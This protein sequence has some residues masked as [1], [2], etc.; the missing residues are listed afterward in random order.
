VPVL[1]YSAPVVAAG[2]VVGIVQAGAS[3]A[4]M[5]DYLHGLRLSLVMVTCLAALLAFLGG[6]YV[7]G[8]GL[9]PIHR[10]TQTA[11][12]IGEKRDFGRRVAHVG[13]TDEVGELALTFN[14]MLEQ[15]EAAY[16]N[17]AEALQNQRRFVADASHELRTPLTTIR[18]NAELLGLDP[19][20]PRADRRAALGDIVS[21]T[22]RLIALV[23]DLLVLARA[24]A[25]QRPASE[26]VLLDGLLDDL[27]RQA[28]LLAPGRHVDRR[29][30]AGLAAM[31]DKDAMRQVLLNLLENAFRHT[32]SDTA[33]R[34]E[35]EADGQEVV[36]RVVDE[37]PGIPP[38]DQD[39]VFE[40][41][42]RGRLS[43]T[44]PGSGLGLSIAKALVEVQGGT[45]AVESRLGAGSTFT[46]R[47]PRA[48]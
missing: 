5:E 40:R 7:A 41:F 1:V 4:L 13:P 44:G 35:A 48:D 10:I 6:W 14:G 42:Q 17:M 28:S 30:E 8:E 9:R 29:I 36:V 3:L 19:P 38:E 25:G 22:D 39:R 45:I 34:L 23:G 18:G 16:R 2:T 15:L 12:E 46:V 27:L 20:I 47:L 21:E 37:G 31:A 26:R 43:R 33:V 24:D 11:R 32:P